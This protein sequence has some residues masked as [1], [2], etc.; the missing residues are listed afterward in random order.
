MFKTLLESLTESDWITAT[1]HL[2]MW[3]NT[4]WM[5]Q[6]KSTLI[7]MSLQNS[8]PLHQKQ[9]TS[10]STVWELTL[11]F[12]KLWHALTLMISGDSF[13][14][15]EESQLGLSRDLFRDHC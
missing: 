9:I 2:F 14:G 5:Q 12:E 11:S 15:G 8:S 13:T 6:E 10:L 3:Q 1:Q 7:S 4:C